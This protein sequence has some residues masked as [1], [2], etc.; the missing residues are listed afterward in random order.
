MSNNNKKELRMLFL[1]NLMLLLHQRFYYLHQYCLTLTLLLLFFQKKTGGRLVCDSIGGKKVTKRE[2]IPFAPNG[3]TVAS[4]NK[5]INSS[6]NQELLFKVGMCSSF[7]LAKL[8]LRQNNKK[9]T[10]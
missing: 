9:R 2:S 10:Q 6:F 7:H 1:I 3:V 5:I 8:E 4:D